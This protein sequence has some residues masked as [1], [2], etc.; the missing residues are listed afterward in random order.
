MK[1]P[2]YLI[3][4]SL[5]FG[6]FSSQAFAQKASEL[7]QSVIEDVRV[8]VDNHIKLLQ[9]EIDNG[10][11]G[12]DVQVN[13]GIINYYQSSM[14]IWMSQDVNLNF[15]FASALGS[16]SSTSNF[17]PGGID[18]F[19]TPSQQMDDPAQYP[20]ELLELN[21]FRLANPEARS[22]IANID[23]SSGSMATISALVNFIQTNK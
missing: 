3:C 21:I 23:V 12:I 5:L 4:I 11:P 7:D 16:V 1:F 10:V 17:S 9:D 19:F 8:T 18:F 13:E 20:A 15:A 14:R 2:A 6:G 22:I